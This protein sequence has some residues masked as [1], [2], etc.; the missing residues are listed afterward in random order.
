M[1]WNR[2]RIDNEIR[3]HRCFDQLVRPKGVDGQNTIDG[4]G[5]QLLGIALEFQI[6]IDGIG[7]TGNRS[8]IHAIKHMQ[9]FARPGK[10][11]KARDTRIGGER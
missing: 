4:T 1:T 3:G 8:G 5:G 10:G 9:I 2:R 7:K 6:G 11:H